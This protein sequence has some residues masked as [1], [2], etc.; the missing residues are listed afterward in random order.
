MPTVN[1]IVE[2]KKRQE[3]E[4]YRRTAPDVLDL[5]GAAKFL[6]LTPRALSEAVDTMAIPCRQ[7]G[8]KYIFS[9]AA[10]V[11]WVSEGK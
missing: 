8:R 2:S 5:V 4:Q 9:R 10:L 3:V 1:D 6:G 7:V 11:Q